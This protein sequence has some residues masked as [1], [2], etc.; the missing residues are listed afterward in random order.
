MNVDLQIAQTAKYNSYYNGRTHIVEHF[1][2]RL[3]EKIQ[4]FFPN[5]PEDI[6]IKIRPIK[7]AN[8]KYTAGTSVG[9]FTLE[10]D[11]RPRNLWKLADTIAHEF[12]HMQ[13][14][15]MGK[16]AMDYSTNKTMRKW[17]DDNGVE[18]LYP[19]KDKNY[20]AYLDL[21]WEVDARN[22]AAEFVEKNTLFI[23]DLTLEV[24]GV[25]S[26]EERKRKR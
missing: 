4:E 20:Q 7:S 19:R 21:P 1:T 26:Y 16:L 9:K 22:R 25:K 15:H 18:T 5:L 13:Q 8:G 6:V 24:Q 2:V 14:K 23:H 17:V 11:C 3:L 12:C 10:L